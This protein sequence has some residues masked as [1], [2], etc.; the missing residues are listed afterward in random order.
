VL[1]DHRPDIR[2][3]ADGV[4][5]FC[6]PQLDGPQFRKR[7]PEPGFLG[8]DL[9][10]I[11]DKA[12]GKGPYDC[13]LM[14]SGGKDSTS[15]LYYLVRRYRLRPLAFMFDHG[16]ETE[17][18]MA[19]VRR[20]TDV[21]GVDLVQVRSYFMHEL[22]AEIIRSRSPVPLCPP[23]SMWYMGLTF[24]VARQYGIKLIV[25]GWTR[26]QMS[27]RG[28]LQGRGKAPEEQFTSLSAA[29][30]ALIDGVRARNPRYRDFPRT[31]EQVKRRHRKLQVISP[32]WFLDEDPEDY[33]AMIRDE[34]GWQPSPLSYPLGSTN[35]LLNFVSAYISLRDYGFTHY[36]IELS[37]LIRRGELSR[38][39]ALAT[40]DVDLA[41]PPYRGVIEDVLGRLGCSWSDLDG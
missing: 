39:E 40:L 16:F 26:G 21:L 37:Q 15:A 24:T 23:C 11:L 38:D 41:Q 14:C 31:M 8:T 13:L 19:N 34:L 30:S 5:D 1:P 28:R 36:H 33:T 6:R 17:E 25:S 32:H 4:C 7:A 3:D 29:T 12:R 20:A 22:F 27:T 9:T 35:C 10:R 2:V 18:A